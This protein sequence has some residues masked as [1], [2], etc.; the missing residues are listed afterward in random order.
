VSKVRA[1]LFGGFFLLA[2]SAV[3]AGPVK[4]SSDL[5]R[6]ARTGTVR[7]IVQFNQQPDDQDDQRIM[8]RKRKTQAPLGIA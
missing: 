7:V 8:I 5:E 3:N 4:I 6:S 2:S 1:I